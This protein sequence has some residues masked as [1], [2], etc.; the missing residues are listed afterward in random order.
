MT[1]VLLVE[2][3]P[4]VADIICDYL[5][6]LEEYRITVASTAENALALCS[7][8][9]DVILLD[10]MLPDINGIDLCRQLRTRLGCP[11]LFISCIDDTDTIVRALGQGGDDYI[12]KPFD[13]QILHARIQANLRRIHMD[14]NP[15]PAPAM[16]FGRLTLNAGK[17]LLILDGRHYPLSSTETRILAFL[18]SHPG[19]HFT[20]TELYRKIWGKPSYG[21][22]RTVL[23]HIHNLRKK[24]E[25]DPTTPQILR[26]VPG[27]GYVFVPDAC[28]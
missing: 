5:E 17:S 28:H 22:A 18:M 11:I 12:V 13:T 19:Q 25:Q 8:P 1:N 4:I 16:T 24:I 27:K 3:D 15:A 6:E 26:N 7:I 2:D 20:S 21:D 14:R 23:V 10:I 9:F